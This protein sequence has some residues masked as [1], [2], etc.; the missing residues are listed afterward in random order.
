M[1]DRKIKFFDRKQNPEPDEGGVL[2]GEK[3][4]RKAIIQPTPTLGDFP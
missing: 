1:F 4:K 2:D 3:P